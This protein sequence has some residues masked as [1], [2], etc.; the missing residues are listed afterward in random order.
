MTLGVVF[1]RPY[2]GSR[3]DEIGF[4]NHWK[5]LGFGVLICGVASFQF[6]A[7]F[8]HSPIQV[9]FPQPE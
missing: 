2:F 8:T 6:T 5:E 1:T 3:D 9:I 4:V 7:S